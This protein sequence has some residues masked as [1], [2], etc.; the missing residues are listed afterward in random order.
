MKIPV[1]NFLL[2]IKFVHNT[3]CGRWKE[4]GKNE[5]KR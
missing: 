5:E 1:T 4:K 3:T 2:Q